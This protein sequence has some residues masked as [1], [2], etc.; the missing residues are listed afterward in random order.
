M[1]TSNDNSVR[2]IAGRADDAIVGRITMERN[3]FT[4]LLKM[5]GICLIL[6]GMAAC[7]LGMED[8]L[9]ACVFSAHPPVIEA[10]PSC[11]EETKGMVEVRQSLGTKIHQLQT[12]QMMARVIVKQ[13]VSIGSIILG[14][15]LCRSG[16]I[17][18]RLA[19]Y[20]GSERP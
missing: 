9:K 14:L 13:V 7:V 17:A 15:Y 2:K 20:G 3:L 6:Y 4:A 5:V 12:Q 19:G 1:S 11:P 16:K 10:S 8:V 18:F